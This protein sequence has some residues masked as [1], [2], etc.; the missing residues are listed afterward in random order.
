MP[1]VAVLSLDPGPLP[2]ITLALMAGIAG[3]YARRARTL[4]REARPVP[5]GRQLCFYGGLATIL[6]AYV[7]PIG[8]LSD[9]LLVVHMVQHLL[10]GD[11][12]ALLIVL[13]MTG[14]L[15]A[16]A[17]RIGPLNRLRVL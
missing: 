7:S 14:P 13:G 17:L 12:G 10:M 11:V 8:Q 2:P 15:I 3:L 9:E 1:S 5:R 16:P 4:A 6:L